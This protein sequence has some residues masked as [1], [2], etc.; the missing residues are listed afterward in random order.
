MNLTQEDICDDICFAAYNCSLMRIVTQKMAL[1]K[2]SN[3]L[4]NLP[5]FFYQIRYIDINLKI[6]EP[7]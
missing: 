2:H 7:T 3:S 5:E 6:P 4:Q 1:L